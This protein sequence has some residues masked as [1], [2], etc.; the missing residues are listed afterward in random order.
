MIGTVIISLELLHKG[1]SNRALREEGIS[2][3][4]SHKNEAK[5][6]W[7]ALQSYYHSRVHVF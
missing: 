6:W 4:K 5:Q 3:I 1:N 2:H 7:E